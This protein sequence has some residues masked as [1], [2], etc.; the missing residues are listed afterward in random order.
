MIDPYFDNPDH[1][2]SEE[3]AFAAERAER[4]GAIDVARTAFAEAAKLEENA[5]WKIPESEPRLRSLFGI[6]A[7][8]LWLKA[9]EWDDAARA[10]CTF[11]AFPKFL[12]PDGRR[13]LE[14]LVDRAWRSRELSTVFGRERDAFVGLETRLLGGSIRA[15]VAPAGIVAERREVLVPML[16]RVAEWRGRRKFRRAGVSSFAA[17]LEVVE[18]PARA[19]SFGVRLFVG[20]I[21]Q[22]VTAG[23]PNHPRD[24]I[25]GF[26]EL[27]SAAA[28]DRLASVS[29]DADYTRAFARAFR[30][31]A[32][33]GTHV[34][35]VE[36][37]QVDARSGGRPI[38]LG[39]QQ[40]TALTAILTQVDRARPLQLDGVLK[41]VNLRG[42]EPTIWIEREKDPP[43]RL[44]I[45]KGEHDDTIGPKLNRPVRVIGR[46]DVS[47]DGEAEEWADDVVLLEDI[48]NER[49][50]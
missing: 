29:E 19:A 36:F 17:S 46:H 39:P 3:L 31:L 2:R 42:R 30:D 33:D 23:E 28:E 13:E 6:S 18:A 32:G 34:A 37:A 1:R 12:T 38:S 45:A 47:E 15:G 20:S 35:S 40:R 44:R 16:Y 8:S 49:A 21:G 10:G 41:S 22:Q 7:V 50:A 4:G 27:A 14:S 43:V 5:A 24:I 48:G 11:L 26:L 9:A 25:S